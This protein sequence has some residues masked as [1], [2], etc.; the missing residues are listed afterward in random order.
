MQLADTAVVTTIVD[1]GSNTVSTSSYHCSQSQSESQRSTSAEQHSASSSSHMLFSR[2]ASGRSNEEEDMDAVRMS[3][4]EE[5]LHTHTHTSSSS[6]SSSALLYS[7]ERG[8]GEGQKG[9]EDAH[10]GYY[11]FEQDGFAEEYEEEEEEGGGDVS[12]HI[13]GLHDYRLDETA[14]WY[15][16]TISCALIHTDV[17][18]T[19]LR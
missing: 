18:I 10:S 8:Q 14:D 11:D 5:G 3:G 12:G 9:G 15:G 16:T 6:S 4:D 17:M 1:D 13:I 7:E 19:T 2:G